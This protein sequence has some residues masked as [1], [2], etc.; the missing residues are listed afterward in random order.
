MDGTFDGGF[1][2][3]AVGDALAAPAQGL[4]PARIIQLFGR[5]EGYLDPDKAFEQTP[6]HFRL[7]GL[8]SLP[9]QEALCVAESLI[10]SGHY[11]LNDIRDTFLA[12]GQGE[13][14]LGSF[15]GMD[16]AFR[17]ALQ[18]LKEGKDLTGCGVPHPGVGAIPRVLPLAIFFRDDPEAMKKAVIECVLLTHNDPSAISGALAYAWTAARFYK[19]GSAVLDSPSDF[20]ANLK[21]YV[22]KGEECL[23]DDYKKHLPQEVS[24]R[25]YYSMSNSLD[26]LLPCLRENNRDLVKQTILAEANRHKP[27]FPV[28]VVSQDFAPSAVIYCLYIALSAKTYGT[29][30]WDTIHEGKEACAM[31]ALV[32]GLLGLRFGLDGIPEEWR[33]GLLNADQIELRGREMYH[34]FPDWGERIDLVTMEKRYTDM[35]R[36]EIRKRMETFVEEKERKERKHPP[37]P[38]SSSSVKEGLPPQEEA[39]F[40]PPPSVVF[41]SAL[42]DPIQAK[43]DKSLRGR[44]RIEWKEDRRQKKKSK[45]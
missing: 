22:R 36:E 1:A 39:P 31:T 40:A 19:G 27:P 26:I 4:K 13:G 44:K 3:M 18:N 24:T 8:Y 6:S 30:I 33:S 29:G 15:R 20:I 43:K 16:E 5:L 23:E 9:T 28:S 11:D 7:K 25:L 42:P 17:K 45:S 35:E 38:K 2:G 14:A 21:K 37:R 12:L 32:G 10:V 41:G 34:G